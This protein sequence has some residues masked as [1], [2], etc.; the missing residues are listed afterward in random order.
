MYIQLSPSA[1]QT[2]KSLDRISDSLEEIP[3]SIAEELLSLGLAYQSRTCCAIN[4]TAAGRLW[5]NQ[6]AK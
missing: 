2:L 6:H 4:M 1:A 5:L 3:R